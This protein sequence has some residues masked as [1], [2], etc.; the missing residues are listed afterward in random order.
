MVETL[1]PLNRKVRAVAH[2]RTPA[3]QWNYPTRAVGAS[4]S[5]SPDP[6]GDAAEPLGPTRHQ[7]FSG[8]ETKRSSAEWWH[9]QSHVNVPWTLLATTKT[10]MSSMHSEKYIIKWLLKDIVLLGLGDL[11]VIHGLCKNTFA[12]Y[13]WSHKGCFL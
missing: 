12:S 13:H 4:E 1:S 9:L 6:V 5:F 10:S 3:V 2:H 7:C 8:V 11:A